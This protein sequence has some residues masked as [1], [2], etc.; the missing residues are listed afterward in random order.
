M[1]VLIYARQSFTHEQESA[2]LAVQASECRKWAQSRGAEIVGEYDDANVSSEHYPDCPEGREAARIDRGYQRWLKEQRT[3]GRKQFKEGLGKAFQRIAEGGVTHLLVYTR[4]RLGRTADGSYLDRFLTNYLMEHRVSLVCVQ[5]GTVLDFS[6]DFMT[7]VM[8]L[9]DSL[10]YRGLREKA[11][12][13]LASIDRRINSYRKWSN[14]FGVQMADGQVTFMENHAEAVRFA[15]E[16]VVA[17]ASYP[18]ILKTMNSTYRALFNGRQCYQSTLSNMLR[19]PVYAGY[20][21]NRDGVMDK[22]VNIPEPVVSYSVW[23]EAQRVMD[24]KVVKASKLNFRG[25]RRARWLP[26]SRMLKCS[27]GRR[28]V[29]HV[30]RGKT[31]YECINP[32]HTRRIEINDDVL[33]TVQKIFVIGLIGSTKKLAELDN[34]SDKADR[35]KAEIDALTASMVAKMS[36]VETA[37]DAELFRPVLQS[38]KARISTKKAE[39]LDAQAMDGTEKARMKERLEQDFYNV[40]EGELLGEEDYQRLL[41][42]TISS[43]VVMD[44][45]VTVH[46][47]DGR[48]FSIPR[49]E[50]K[51]HARRLMKCELLC[52]ATG[53]D[54]EDIA[55]YQLHFF[56]GKLE[57]LTGGTVQYEDENVSVVIHG[58]QNAG[59]FS[60]R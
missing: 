9:K 28:M 24:A 20:M 60:D 35:L 6:D 42:D 13:S 1:K 29:I 2:S 8:S 32:D 33:R 36:L 27:C 31:V 38:L 16:Q 7:L 37:E 40:M 15:F 51:H 59:L 39:L 21:T 14:A 30:D 22:A 23:K 50:G 4:N 49:I 25:H 10:D 45:A 46:L 26:L 11:K 53:D 3:A 52:D 18:S 41:R 12:A 55:H 34:A 43:L 48:T 17:G 5:D 19:N 54:V 47:V 57:G 44:D 56:D 58:M